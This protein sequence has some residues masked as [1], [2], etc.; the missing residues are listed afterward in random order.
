LRASLQHCAF[1]FD[2]PTKRTGGRVVLV[3]TVLPEADQRLRTILALVA[4]AVEILL[5]V[6]GFLTCFQAGNLYPQFN[7]ANGL[8]T[9][10][11]ARFPKQ[12]ISKVHRL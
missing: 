12:M 6:A 7:S 8:A 10:K 1:S 3:G 5:V 11:P 9:G 2:H 4:Q